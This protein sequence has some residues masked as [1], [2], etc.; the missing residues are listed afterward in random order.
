MA[1]SAY[2]THFDDDVLWTLLLTYYGT[3]HFVKHQEFPG[4]YNAYN[5]K[6]LLLYNNVMHL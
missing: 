4:E 1:L 6:F 3:S 2:S 5:F